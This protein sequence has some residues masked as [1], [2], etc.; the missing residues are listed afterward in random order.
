MGLMWI[1]IIGGLV[2]VVAASVWLGFLPP[3]HATTLIRISGGQLQ[4]SRGGLKAHAKLDVSEILHDA[5]VS[6]G[7]IAITRHNRVSFSRRIPATV[8]QGLRNVLLNQWI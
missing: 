6:H 3:P 5:G 1:L 4:V 2:S 7:F 8:H